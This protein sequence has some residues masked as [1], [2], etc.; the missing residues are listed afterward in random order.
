MTLI[1]RAAERLVK[2]HGGLRKASAAIGIKA[3]YLSRLKNGI[4]TNPGDEILAKLGIRR[5]VTYRTNGS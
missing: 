3:P 2:R 4:Q 1:Q 5:H